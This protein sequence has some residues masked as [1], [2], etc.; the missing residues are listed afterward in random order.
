LR[1]G[2]TAVVAVALW[3]TTDLAQPDP[4]AAKARTDSEGA[5]LP[6]GAITRLGSGRFRHDGQPVAPVTFS[7]DGRLLASAHNRGVSVFD[8]ATGRAVHTF[9]VPDQHYPKVARFLADGKHLAVGSMADRTAELT[10][11][12]LLSPGLTSRGA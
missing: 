12:S 7:P 5:P 9:R 6:A 2:V 1:S 4:P 10:I 11:H 3:T 8:A